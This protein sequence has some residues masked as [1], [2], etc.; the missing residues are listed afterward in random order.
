MNEMKLLNLWHYEQKLGHF[1]TSKI[2]ERNVGITPLD[3]FA[4]ICQQL[5]KEHVAMHEPCFR[6]S[7]L[8]ERH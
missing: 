6:F 8:T 7:T 5:P 2:V 4:F 3:V 1:Q